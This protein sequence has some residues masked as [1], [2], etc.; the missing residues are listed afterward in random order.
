MRTREDILDCPTRTHRVEELL[1][2]L[3]TWGPTAF[4][5]FLK[6]LAE[7]E[8]S[9]VAEKLQSDY[10]H[11]TVVKQ[12]DDASPARGNFEMQDL[13]MYKQLINTNHIT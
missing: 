8:H 2:R 4:Q 5:V 3:P 12:V 1:D 13:C 10:Q 7:S 6:A 11:N 9:H